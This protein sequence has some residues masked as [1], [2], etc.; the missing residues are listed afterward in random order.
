MVAVPRNAKHPVL[1]HHFLN[2]VLDEKNGYDNFANYVGYQPPFTKLDPDRLIAD[3]V[4]PKNLADRDRAGE[5]LRRRVP[6]HR[7]HAGRR[8]R[9]AE[10]LGRVQGGCLSISAA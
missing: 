4:V 9:L 2:Y 10:R 1:A 7:A 6:A 3:G 5:R 8:D